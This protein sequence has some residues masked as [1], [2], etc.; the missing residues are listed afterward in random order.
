MIN[1]YPFFEKI[2]LQR[3]KSPHEIYSIHEPDVQCISKGKEHKKYEFGNKVSIIRS[4]TGVILGACSFRNEY[5]GHTIK[6]SLEQVFRLTG[7]NIQRL[8]ADRGYRGKKRSTGL[9]YS[10]LIGQKPKTPTINARRNI[11]CFAS[12]QE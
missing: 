10:F 1:C 8:A 9:K 5:D 4:S 7:K 6:E 11:S 12:V 2:L 3:R